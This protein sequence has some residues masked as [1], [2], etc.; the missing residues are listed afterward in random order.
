[1]YNA[2]LKQKKFQ[3]SAFT[4][5]L[6][7]TLECAEDMAIDVP[8]IATY[9]A[10]IIAHMMNKD[11]SVEFLAEACELIKYKRICADFIAETLLSASNRLG[12]TTVA[13][14]FNKVSKLKI[15]DFLTGVPDSVEF[16]KTK[17][18]WTWLYLTKPELS[19][20]SYFLKTNRAQKYIYLIFYFIL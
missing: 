11:T 5:A 19:F 1:M 6:K 18:S 15:H 3:L 12:H 4:Q 10:Q 8:K 9:L 2:V 13:D 16:L 17:V 20:I 14:I 7:N